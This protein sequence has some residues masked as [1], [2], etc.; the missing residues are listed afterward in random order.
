MAEPKFPVYRRCDYPPGMGLCYVD[1][2]SYV[3]GFKWT[4]VSVS[5]TGS[6]PPPGSGGHGGTSH[7]SSTY[8][9]TTN[10]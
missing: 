5:S 6:G 8:I 3:I 7:P 10:A 9:G 2:A 1:G 4:Q